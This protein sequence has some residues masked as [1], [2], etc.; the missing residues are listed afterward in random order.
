MNKNIKHLRTNVFLIRDN[1]ICLGLKK[2]HHDKAF[3]VGKYNGFGG[4]LEAGETIY[5]A[6]VRELQE[7]AG[8]VAKSMSKV[9][10]LNFMDS[11]GMTVH[12]YLCDKWEGEPIETAEM[13]PKWFKFDKI[14]YDKMW[15][16]DTLWLDR[17]LRGEKLEA[18]FI[19]E[20]NNDTDG[21]GENKIVPEK[22]T[23]NEVKAFKPE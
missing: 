1:E 18:E 13:A 14:P 11:Y 23:I 16:D 10:I 12:T 6:A 20:N 9:A 5:E 22:C 4:K 15:D 19:F 8:V 17:V 2:Q 3:G 7:E 21:K